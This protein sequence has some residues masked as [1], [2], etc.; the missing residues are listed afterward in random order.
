MTRWTR[1][2]A[3]QRM[4]SNTRIQEILLLEP[5]LLEFLIQAHTQKTGDSYNRI[6]TYVELRN[7]VIPLVGWYAEHPD[8]RTSS[9]Y[10]VVIETISDLL[11]PDRWDIEIPYCL[12]Y[13]RP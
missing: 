8:L 1:K 6:Q 11:P 7:A 9:D 10:M 12:I 13:P 2:S 4:L 3:Y 5:R